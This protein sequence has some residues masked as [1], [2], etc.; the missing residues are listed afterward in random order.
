MTSKEKVLKI[1]PYSTSRK[2]KINGALSHWAV[3]I[4]G[5]CYG[6]QKRKSWAWA[7]AL[8]ILKTEIK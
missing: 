1:K 4:N 3:N 6:F 7:E 5:V 8:K 2:I